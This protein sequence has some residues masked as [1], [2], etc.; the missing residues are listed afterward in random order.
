LAKFKVSSESAVVSRIGIKWEGIKMKVNRLTIYFLFAILIMGI[1]PTAVLF[2]LSRTLP[3]LIIFAVT[4][5]MSIGFFMV[6]LFSGKMIEENDARAKNGEERKK[7]K[8]RTKREK[9]CI[10]M[11]LI[12]GLGMT[13]GMGSSLVLFFFPML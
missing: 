7:W 5:S 9:L 13:L 1:G 3:F 8:E 2:A 4:V 11:I 10:I 12:S 6:I